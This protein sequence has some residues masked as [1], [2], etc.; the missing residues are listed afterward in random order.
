MLRYASSPR[1]SGGVE[2]LASA[3]DAAPSVT[4]DAA[5]SPSETTIRSPT[6]LT[7]RV[8]FD[9]RQPPARRARQ[10]IAAMPLLPAAW[11]ACPTGGRLGLQEESLSK[12]RPL[13]VAAG[14]LATAAVVLP[15]ASALPAGAQ[16]TPPSSTSST[17]APPATTP[18]TR[19]AEAPGVAAA[20]GAEAGT[21][22][23]GLPAGRPSESA[24]TF[25]NDPTQSGWYNNEPSLAPSTVAK[26]VFGQMFAA[27]VNGQVYSAP[28]VV[29][30]TLVLGTET[31]RVYGLDPKTGAQKWSTNLGVPTQSD[32]TDLTPT[33]GITST[34]A[35]DAATNTAYFVSKT[36][37]SGSSGPMKFVAH[38][39]DTLDGTVKWSVDIKGPATNDPSVSMGAERLLQRPALYVMDGVIYAAFGGFCDEASYHGW[40]VGISTS[41][42]VLTRW[43]DEAN[44]AIASPQGGIWQG[45]GPITSDKP[46]QLLV[47]TANGNNPAVG[48][49]TDPAPGALGQSIV[50]LAVQPDHSLLPVDYFSPA[51]ADDLS[52]ADLGIGSGAAELLPSEYFGTPTVPNLAVTGSKHGSIYV[53]DRSFLGGRGQGPSGGDGIVQRFDDVG[54]M[55]STPAFWVGDGGYFYQTV[56]FHGLQ[57]YQQ[58][59]GAGDVP[60][61]TLAASTGPVGYGSSSPIVTSDGTTSG[62]ALV[63]MVVRLDAGD[64]LRAYDAVPVNGQFHL[65]AKFSVGRFA[66]FNRITVAGGRVYVGTLD[67]RVLA[68][69][70]RTTGATGEFTAISPNRILDTRI[71]L[72]RPGEST[73]PLGEGATYDVQVTGTAGIPSSP[74]PLAVVLNVTATEPTATSFLRIWPTSGAAPPAVSNLNFVAGQTVPNLV[75]VQLNTTG[76]LSVFNKFGDVHVIFDVVGYYANSDGAPGSRFHSLAPSRLFDTRDSGTPIG[77]GETQP[78]D[79]L[80]KGGVPG[81]GTGVTAVVMNVTVTDPTWDGYITV[82]PGDVADR[83]TASNLNFVAGQ[84]V[85]NLVT[86]K[87]PASGVIN[88]YNHQGSSAGRR[89]CRW[90]LRRQSQYRGGPVPANRSDAPL[91]L[92]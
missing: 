74:A 80:G 51:N 16:T 27:P 56:A 20:V 1:C 46:G 48:P 90:V 86:V 84:T 72:G 28:T 68:F 23:Y 42:T 57:A 2:Q 55:W 38:A 61:F 66:K 22:P 25:A 77:A 41:G 47:V 60:A 24:V 58:G 73:A 71:G 21:I 19:G 76:K 35:V 70:L 39:I 5:D 65:R 83:P 11:L 43:T 29:G 92:A 37:E 82:Y 75:T 26:S 63:W 62:S 33:V 89:R 69:G 30:N 8:R 50:R 87:V 12:Y 3:A 36:Y 13:W 10:T 17:T 49:V 6:R 14:I 54:P 81:P 4:T 53:V 52:A 91:R 40:V 15:S 44:Q 67:G 59:V 32:C 64:E 79:V 34:P 85:P 31:N 18:K 45:A 78:F 7:C 88:F 9:I